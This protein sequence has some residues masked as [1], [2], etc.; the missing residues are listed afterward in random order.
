LRTPNAAEAVAMQLTGS[1]SVHLHIL[2]N[3]LRNAVRGYLIPVR[4][5]VELLSKERAFIYI[6]ELHH[7]RHLFT[8][9]ENIKGK[10]NNR[11]HIIR[12][13]QTIALSFA[14]NG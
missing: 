1:I 8:V 13:V 6:A 5:L 11:F 3:G 10:R 14:L 12:P 7:L 9:N 2:R 4:L